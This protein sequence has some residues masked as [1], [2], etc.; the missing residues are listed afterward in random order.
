MAEIET[1]GRIWDVYFKRTV[2][3]LRGVNLPWGGLKT[4]VGWIEVD[5]IH[6]E[7]HPIYPLDCCGCSRVNSLHALLNRAHK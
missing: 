6:L 3:K 1:R 2:Q 7:I 4:V 5:W